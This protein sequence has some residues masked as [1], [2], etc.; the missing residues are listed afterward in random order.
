MRSV[1]KRTNVVRVLPIIPV[2][3]ALIVSALFAAGAHAT[4]GR[5]PFGP[6]ANEND[7]PGEAERQKAESRSAQPESSDT[8]TPLFLQGA[9]IGRR[10]IARLSGYNDGKS[11]P[12]SPWES[13]GPTIAVYPVA[14]SRT[15]NSYVTA[16][17]VTALAIDPRCAIASADDA[18]DD[19]SNN[20]RLYVGAAGGGVWRTD[21]P[22]A[23][24]PRWKFTS[25]SFATNA[26]GAL[27]IDPNDPD[28]IYAGTGEPNSSADS[29]AGLGIYRSDDQGMHWERLSATLTYTGPTGPVTVADGFDNLSISGIVIDPRDSQTFYVGTTLGV[30]GVSATVGSVLPPNVAAPGVYKTNDGGL[31]FLQIWNGGGAPCA[32]FGGSCATTWGVDRIAL[33]PVDPDIVYAAATA[34]GI[35]RSWAKDNAGAFT[36]VYFSQNQANPRVD[37]TDFAL[38]QLPNGK[39]RI[40]AA[41][42]ATGVYA[43][44]PAPLTAYS[45]VWRLDD[46]T[47]PAAT[48]VAEEALVVPGGGVPA[49]GGWKPL[50]AA[51]VGAPGYA[52][53]NFCT[54]QCW[55]DMGIYTPPG[56][57]D[58]VFVLGSY[59]YGETYFGISNARAVLRSTTAGE[60][61]PRNN[62]VTFTD[63]TF[64]GQT[65]D[66]TQLDWLSQ[67][68]A[69][70]PDQHALAFAPANSDVWFEGSDGGVVRS[71]SLYVSIANSCA[72]RGLVGSELLTCQRLL[73]SVPNKLI[74]LNAGLNTLQF[75]SLSINPQNPLGE[76][77][78]GTQDNG[79]FQYEGSSSV[80]YESVGGDGGLSGFNASNPKTRFHT[81]YGAQ[82]DINYAGGDPTQWLW[83]SDPFQQ[84]GERARFYIPI[85]ADP[86]AD[87]GGSMFAGLQWIWR[88]TDNGGDP[89]FLASNCNEFGPFTNTGKC[90]D[91]TH[92]G[93][94]RLTGGT[95]SFVARTSGDTGTLWAGTASGRVYIFKNADAADPKLAGQF[96]V[97]DVLVANNSTPVR[98]VAGIAIDPTNP[99][100]GWVAYGGYNSVHPVSQQAVGGHVFEVTWSGVATDKAVFTLLD[101]TGDGALGD[102]PINSLVRD[103][104][105]GDLYAATD[106][107][108]LR[109]S[110]RT[111]H[112]S[113]ASAGMPMVEV[114]GLAIDQATRVL[115]AA[116]HGRGAWRLML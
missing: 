26:I 82:V 78:G 60:P 15:N 115:Y 100:H 91:W 35:W 99:N 73:S 29:S 3:L 62:N 58:T 6:S 42:G 37:R 41:T 111:G 9:S 44:Y 49:A 5:E 63:L 80:W 39:T 106:F 96:E 108:V 76:L 24:T 17:R 110:A 81:Y 107:A 19:E 32:P 59:N 72:A 79:T 46:A 95:V 16:G 51:A 52:T 54:G 114:S 88:T 116:S 64:D 31:T 66:P 1:S 18:R 105:T 53:N 25:G 40:Y 27:T 38:A 33:D 109:R 85:I 14:T 7:I 93:K 102:L 45:Q 47:R 77:Q 4:P 28:V 71:S 23:Q 86:R 75:Q 98:F 70:H 43:G 8:P 48:L 113:L 92:L 65:P 11:G 55:Y 22:F 34:V 87:R 57:P 10:E 74:S 12:K 83:I 103:D 68:T 67:T 36:Q 30:R 50:T 69:V 20:C 90:G 21:R 61:D 101:G 104:K 97:S 56:R 94:R 13:I 84:S 112:W 89:A 2:A